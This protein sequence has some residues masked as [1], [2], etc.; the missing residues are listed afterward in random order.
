MFI[1]DEDYASFL[2]ENALFQQRFNAENY[3]F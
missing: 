3:K 1:H 2:C